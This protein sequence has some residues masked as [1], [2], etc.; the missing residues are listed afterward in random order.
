MNIHSI[1]EYI[2]FRLRVAWQREVYPLYTESFVTNVIKSSEHVT[3]ELEIE[4]IRDKLLSS[5][6]EIEVHDYG[7]GSKTKNANKTVGKRAKNSLKPKKQALF[8]GRLAKW[9]EA[10]YII[11]LGTSY[12]ITS[13]YLSAFSPKT[14]IVTLEG[15]PVT[16]QI[17]H[18]NFNSLNN[19]NILL[20]QGEFSTHFKRV[21]SMVEGK[22]TLVFIDGN[23]KGEA[24]LSYFQQFND[25]VGKDSAFVIDDINWSKDMKKSWNKL[26]KL[27]PNTL[28][29]DLFQLGLVFLNKIENKAS[30]NIP[31]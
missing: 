23:H 11:E 28:Y 7:A 9:F 30:F 17:A 26:N 12:G 2:K 10:E 27:A 3:E 13:M 25:V 24:L 5:T 29:V 16:A 6:E 18:R 22:K 15:D 21:L 14:K 1:I 20:L 19:T 8:I 4:S 31:N